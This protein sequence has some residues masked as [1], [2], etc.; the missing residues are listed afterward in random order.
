MGAF[1]KGKTG[2]LL[3]A[4]L[5]LASI[6]LLASGLREVSFRPGRILAEQEAQ[7]VSLPV[8][9][10]VENLSEIPLWKQFVAWAIIFLIILIISTILSPDLRRRVLKTFLRFT[11]IL[12][13]LYYLARNYSYLFRGLTPFSTQGMVPARQDPA[14]GLPPP[15][16]EAPHV[17][18]LTAFLIS[19]AVAVALAALFWGISRWWRRRQEF[20]ALQRPLDDLA[21]IARDSLQRLSAGNSWD[22]VITDSY[23]RMSEVVEKRRGIARPHAVTPSEFA[24]R[25][26]RAGLP[27]EA[28]RTLTRLFE[29]VRYGARQ[30]SADEN[31]QAVACLTAI[32]NA[33]GEAQ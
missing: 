29:R 10:L 19:A 13:A 20:L 30:S 23:M 3:F 16:F 12:A 18:P 8:A 6:T 15:V 33:C 9:R 32:L 24:G 5:G 11:L 31:T 22:D 17:S 4:I 7:T 21:E 25:L 2:V 28:V 14:E 27:G 1:F 26:E